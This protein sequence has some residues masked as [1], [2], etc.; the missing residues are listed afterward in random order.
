MAFLNPDDD[1]HDLAYAY[2]ADST[3]QF[4][5]T[6]WVLAE[7][8]NY[9]AKGGYRKLFV[10]LVRRLEKDSRWKIE[11]LTQE[12]F[13]RGTHLYERRPDKR[14]SLTDCISF[15][16][17]KEKRIREA[18]TADHHFEQAGFQALLKS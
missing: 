5:T 6:W 3:S 2:M 17:L 4:I 11:P 1:C 8:G 14:W 13:S 16:I 10:P 9:L 7:L 15:I 18:L 12:Q